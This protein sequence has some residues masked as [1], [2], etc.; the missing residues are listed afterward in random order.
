MSFQR[1][2]ALIDDSINTLS[3]WSEYPINF[4]LVVHQKKFDKGMHTLGFYN[5]RDF[6]WVNENLRKLPEEMNEKDRKTFFCD[7]KTVRR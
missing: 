6:V 7:Y 4:R 3:L 2:L 1:K 5:T